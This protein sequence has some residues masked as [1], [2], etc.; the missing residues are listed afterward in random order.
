M[1][2]AG[3]YVRIFFG[4]GEEGCLGGR[5]E[6]LSMRAGKGGRVGFERFERAS[7]GVCFRGLEARGMG[8]FFEGV[9]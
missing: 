3:G 1:G 4:D 5:F 2:T 7:S 6:G 9:P 8:A